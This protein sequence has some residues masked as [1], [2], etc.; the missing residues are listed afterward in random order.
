MSSV[1]AVF[2]PEM[3][4]LNADEAARESPLRFI[5]GKSELGVLY[6]FRHGLT[7][8]VLT[9]WE[10]YQAYGLNILDEALE[11]GS[12]ILI[13]R[14]GIEPTLLRRM[15][16][17]GLPRSAVAEAT[18]LGAEVVAQA[19]RRRADNRVGDLERIGFIL[20]LDEL[21]LGHR[22]TGQA[23][24]DL[25]V[26]L[27]TLRPPQPDGSQQRSRLSPRA[28]AA[29][30]H[31]ASVIRTQSR[32]QRWLGLED[33]S[34]RFEPVD[35]YGTSISPAYRAG[36]ELA[37]HARKTLSLGD[38][39]ITSMR[40][41]VEVTLGIPVI[42]AELPRDIAGA[43]IA[44]DDP[45]PGH[46]EARGI[47]L[48]TIGANE[49]VWVRRATLAHELGHLLFDP[50]QHLQQVRVDTYQSNEVDPQSFVA[51][52]RVEQRANAFSI[53]FLA[54]MDAVS[55]LAPT[56]VQAASVER[57]MAGFGISHTA[58]RYH[59]S[60]AHYR[61]WDVPEGTHSAAPSDEQRAA[62]DFTLDYFPIASTPLLRRGRFVEAVTSCLK[63]GYI[64]EDSA[65]KYL[66]CSKT[67]LQDNLET[68]S[69]LYGPNGPN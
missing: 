30:A 58:A 37:E 15:E 46:G 6:E 13:N 22:L 12:A 31:A 54:P 69:G 59:V 48:N 50:I 53:A 32:L 4:H 35:D 64:S 11:Y 3:A 45:T 52:D 25:A 18:G 41:L 33:G 34:R 43:T 61:Q 55:D 60:N 7:G 63:K 9:A 10:A 56:P 67:E 20:G 62:E 49:N 57:V 24:D 27:R 17:L 5:R 66:Y 40:H 68:I 23:D 8:H 42:Q 29:F 44:V 1:E 28:V 2:G 39:P 14:V 21:Q 19:E 16:E 65:A 38:E 51:T 26:R 36:Y 47:V